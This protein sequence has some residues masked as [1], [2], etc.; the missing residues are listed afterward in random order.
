M[1]KL[2]TKNTW[3]DEAL[4]TNERYDILT[5]AGAPVES[6]VQINLI[7]T[8]AQAGTAVDATHMNNIEDGI[9][10]LDTRLD[11]VGLT[12]KTT[13]VD[14]DSMALYDSVGAAYGR[15]T[16]AN[17]KATLK[18]YLDTLYA[19]IADVPH[20]AE[21]RL[22]LATATPVTA[23]DVT[24]AT[25][26]YYAPYTGNR[27]AVYNGTRWVLRTFAELSASLAGLAANTNYDVFVYDNAGTLTLDLTAWTNDTTRATALVYQDGTLVKSGATG[28]RYLGTIR[29]TGTTGQCEDSKVKRFV[30]NC[31]NRLGRQMFRALGGPVTYNSATY[32]QWAGDNTLILEFVLGQPETVTGNISVSMSTTSGTSIRAALCV[33]DVAGSTGG[34]FRELGACGFNTAN[35][36]Q[37]ASDGGI[38]TLT[39]GYHYLNPEQASSATPTNTF[40]TGYIR[41]AMNG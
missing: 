25:T 3:T 11:Y 2:Y 10:A 34:T 30:W 37:F 35:G 38:T 29:I 27:L 32:R 21:G 16:W 15:L 24:A 12:S 13:P 7:S 28:R 41:G 6:N 26:L 39:E 19:A 5:D 22:T 8:V 20:V 1:A 33:D 9:D 18:T 23:A 4:A 40:V 14:A 31:Y 36:N 17:L